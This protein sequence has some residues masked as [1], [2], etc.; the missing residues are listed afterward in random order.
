MTVE[1]LIDILKDLPND[2]EVRC[3]QDSCGGS[4]SS[5][6]DWWIEDGELILG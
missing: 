6:D 5:I 2:M 3:M 4:I 1:G